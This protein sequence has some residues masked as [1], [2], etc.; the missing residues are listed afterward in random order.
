MV[1]IMPPAKFAAALPHRER[2]PTGLMY[3]VQT[4]WLNADAKAGCLDDIEN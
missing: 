1:F 3:A 2:A 4:A